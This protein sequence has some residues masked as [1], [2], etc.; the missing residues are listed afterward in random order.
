MDGIG[1]NE[2]LV[3]E[4][5][6]L[7]S[8]AELRDL[9]AAFE[10]RSD[11]SLVDRLRSELKGNHETL[12]LR[13]L[14]K[15]RGEG[16]ADDAKARGQAT[17]LTN[18]IKSG[19][20]MLGGLSNDAQVRVIDIV[21]SC[22]VAQSQ[23]LKSA[24]EHINMG[25]PSLEATI[26][27]KFS[28]HLEDALLLLLQDPLDSMCQRIRAATEGIG[29]N[30]EV[31][32]RII[33]GNDKDVVQQIIARYKL[34]YDV[35]LRVLI[36]K[37]T[38]G[39]YQNALLT[40]MKGED[41]T[42]NYVPPRAPTE[43]TPQPEIVKILDGLVAV[44][45]SMKNWTAALDVDLLKRAAK[46]AGTDERMVVSILCT[47]TKDQIERIDL[48]FRQ[49]HN[50]TLKDYIQREMGGNLQTFLTYTQMAEEE[51]DA[52]QLHEAFKG[53]GC[54]KTVVVEI[55]TTRS[56]KR[57][58]AARRYYE[59]RYDSGLLDRIRSEM[60]GSLA[61]L[62]VRLLE[63]VRGHAEEGKNLVESA[64]FV[65]DELHKGGAARWGTDEKAFIDIL[66]KYNLAEI[67]EIGS[68]YERKHSTSLEAAIKSEFSGDLEMALVALI[69][70]PIDFFCRRLKEAA[71]GLGTDEA[72]INRILGGNDKPTVHAIAGRY[73]Q[74]YNK[75]LVDMLESELSGD[76]KSAV[77]HWVS[78][79]DYTDG[80]ETRAANT[81]PV[82]VA[83]VASTTSTTR[84]VA[85]AALSP[86]AGG[87]SLPVPAAAH[88]A[89]PPPAAY[90]APAPA[91]VA[92][93]GYQ[94]PQVVSYG[95]PPAAAVPM[96]GAAPV[97]AAGMV[98]GMAPPGGA[99]YGQPQFAP[100]G[101][102]MYGQPAQ[103]GLVYG[104]PPLGAVAYGQPQAGVVYGQP[105]QAAMAYGQPVAGQPSGG[106]AV[107][108]YAPQQVAY[109]QAPVAAYGQPVYGMAPAPA[110]A[111]MP[112]PPAYG[113]VAAL[114]P[115]WEEKV[116][117][118]GR[119]YYVNHNTK[120]TQWHRP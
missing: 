71:K 107:Y 58:Q 35:D 3:N 40:Y 10:G 117:P 108:G 8:N 37:E 2:D 51:F 112:P 19:S 68:A 113:A 34:K 97:A 20:S 7:A 56:W 90:H 82:A 18:V 64:E 79:G 66:T 9:K 94:Q 32:S 47:R 86:V 15:G 81:T 119:H 109:G 62:C 6:C 76:Y 14:T 5:M 92:A 42:H 55:L 70:D 102:V 89:L 74:K 29:C 31:V 61:Y 103:Q 105:P 60:G 99:V 114:P 78:T 4:V 36:K 53:I 30:E 44:I 54:N 72:T 39:D 45:E 57:L 52:L 26:K 28:G 98:Y 120:S 46:G 21:A 87:P 106:A 1:C 23:A 16:P 43:A 27:A 101:T 17:E 59:Q 91:P 96:P 67:R 115:G 75:R 11:K 38:G 73:M 50:R 118:D 48:A 83:S 25:K 63:G 93:M 33:G 65:A 116:A 88:G 49:K 110:A 22:S 24:Y 77:V 100:P 12:I 104:Q 84:P 13:L 111:S 95:Q 80:L 69:N 85:T 41:P